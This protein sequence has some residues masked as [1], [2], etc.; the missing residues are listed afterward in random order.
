MKA[1]KRIVILLMIFAITMSM[2]SCVRFRVNNI[3]SCGIIDCNI[4]NYAQKMA[5]VYYASEF[6]PELSELS[7]YT[8]ISYSHTQTLLGLVFFLPMF[9][10]DGIAIW[11]EYPED[12]YEQK[13]ADLFESYDFIEEEIYDSD[14]DLISPLASFEYKG[15]QFQADVSEEYDD[16]SM[17]CKSFI[18]VGYSDELNRIAYLYSYD[19]DL[20]WIANADEDKLSEMHR[21]MDEHFYWNDIK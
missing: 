17:C 5:D 4:D 9:F 12:I 20:D 16:Y 18:L 8:N 19:F 2:T 7:E 11:V 3:S 21:F 6:M 14:G 13:K 10:S 1:T 15:Y